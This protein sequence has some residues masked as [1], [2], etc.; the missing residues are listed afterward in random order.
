MSDLHERDAVDAAGVAVSHYLC[1]G[2]PLG[3]R[4]EVEDHGHGQVEVRGQSCKKGEVFGRQEH[5]DPR[6][7]VTTTVAIRGSFYPRLPVKTR[8]DV[9]KG[10]VADVCRL[11]HT[12]HLEAPVTM[13]QVIAPD[14]LG[15][16]VDVVAS[17]DL[18]RV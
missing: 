14:V 9:P 7:T 12:L 15:T 11:L 8:G 18:P 4:L 13:G 17:R 5:L 2:C 10:R 16:G 6:R 3:C 1:I